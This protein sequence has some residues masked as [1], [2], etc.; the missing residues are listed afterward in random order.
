MSHTYHAAPEAAEDQDDSSLF[1][2]QP[3]PHDN[4]PTSA[5]ADVSAS[6][7]G[8]VVGGSGCGGVSVGGGVGKMSDE[9]SEAG[10]DGRRW[11]EAARHGGAAGGH[12]RSG[13]VCVGDGVGAMGAAQGGAGGCGDERGCP[14]ASSSSTAAD[15]R[16]AS[17]SKI[18]CS[19]SAGA[20]SLESSPLSVVLSHS[21][22]KTGGK[23]REVEVEEEA[24]VEAGAGEDESDDVRLLK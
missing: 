5:G 4:T 1:S 9:S 17:G 13:S 23:R 7:E 14:A 3:P 8:P 12:Q 10:A 6:A 16:G 15:M 2:N 24:D 11:M 18:H 21:A 22:R 20:A 19:P